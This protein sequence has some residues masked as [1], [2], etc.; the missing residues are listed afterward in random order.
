M[1][2]K[3]VLAESLRSSG[4][5]TELEHVPPGH[6]ERRADILTWPPHM[7]R[8]LVLEIQH[9][10]IS[11]GEMFERAA[12]YARL[13]YVQAWLSVWRK[14]MV[15]DK[16]Q[17]IDRYS[18][19]PYEKWIQ[20]F[21]YGTGLWYFDPENDLFRQAKLETCWLTTKDSEWYEDGEYQYSPSRTYP[22]KRWRTLKL[23][24]SCQADDLL[25]DL[26]YRKASTLSHHRWPE[27]RLCALNSTTMRD[28]R[29]LVAAE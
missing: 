2:A 27:C 17:E 29:R 24:Q 16:R 4:W 20:G 14:D 25:F 8:G 9:T 26:K 7:P 6:P 21:N 1:R 12:D 22:S 23:I 13:G 3:V 28:T 5:R 19:P 15:L 10:P 18:A 11:P